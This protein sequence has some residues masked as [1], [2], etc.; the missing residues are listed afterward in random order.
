MYKTVKEFYDCMHETL[1]STVLGVYIARECAILK[2][3][4]FNE[5]AYIGCMEQSWIRM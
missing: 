1:K 2:W 5:N 3:R 4:E